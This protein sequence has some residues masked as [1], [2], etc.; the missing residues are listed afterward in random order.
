MVL[1]RVGVKRYCELIQ[2]LKQAE[3]S[4]AEM[5]VI[6][7]VPPMSVNAVARTIYD[8]LMTKPKLL[9]TNSGLVKKSAKNN[10]KIKRWRPSISTPSGVSIDGKNLRYAGKLTEEML[11]GDIGFTIR[12]VPIAL[13][14]VKMSAGKPSLRVAIKESHKEFGDTLLKALLSI[15]PTVPFEFS[16]H[17][18]VPHPRQLYDLLNPQHA[19]IRKTLL[20][21]F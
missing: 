6:G 21:D 2:K 17:K 18:T 14:H 20:S 9:T 15:I 10:I 1:K 11:H 8:E 5:N 12:G 7:R 3:T 13:A 4:G 19:A 16:Y